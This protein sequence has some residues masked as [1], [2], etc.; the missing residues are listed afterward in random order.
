MIRG[1]PRKY[2]KH[3]RAETGTA[4]YQCVESLEGWTR[5]PIDDFHD[6][7]MSMLVYSINLNKLPWDNKDDED[8][9]EMKRKLCTVE[10]SFYFFF[11]SSKL[12]IKLIFV[13][14]IE[15]RKRNRKRGWCK[16]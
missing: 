9:C 2:E 10:V 14:F 8:M 7:F 12:K 6:L 4:A 5:G 15:N 13:F 3:L 1:K 11:N 16:M